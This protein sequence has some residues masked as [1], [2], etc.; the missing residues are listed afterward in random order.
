MT[1]TI[2]PG[3]GAARLPVTYIEFHFWGG[4]QNIFRKLGVFAWREALCRTL[5]S[6]VFVRGVRGYDPEKI[7]KNGAICCALENI[8]LKFCKKNNCKNIYFYI[9]IIDN[10]LITAHTIF[11]DIKSILFRFGNLHVARGVWGHAPLRK[12][13]KMVQFGA[14]WC[15]FR[16]DLV[17]KIFQKLS[18]FI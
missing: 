7:F 17:F 3:G 5:R 11:S 2:F 6:H 1:N 9:K 4:G 12:F 14:F 10:I 15:V 18:F 13:F 16:S 8:L